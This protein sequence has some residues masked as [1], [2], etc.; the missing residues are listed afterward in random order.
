MSILCEGIL[1]ENGTVVEADGTI[2]HLPL[3]YGSSLEGTGEYLIDAKDVGGSGMVRRQRINKWVGY[4]VQ[5]VK[6]EGHE[7]Y[8]FVILKPEETWPGII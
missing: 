5:F 3:R 7:G 6:N 8:N 1:N 4:K 2:H